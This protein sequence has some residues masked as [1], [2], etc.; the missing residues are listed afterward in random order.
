VILQYKILLSKL[1]YTDLLGLPAWD[2]ANSPLADCVQSLKRNEL[3]WATLQWSRETDLP[4]IACHPADLIGNTFTW[5][6]TEGNQVKLCVSKLPSSL[7][8][9]PVQ[10]PDVPAISLDLDILPHMVHSVLHKIDVS[11][12]LLV[13]VSCS[14]FVLY[15]GIF[16]SR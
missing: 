7:R 1:H 4:F 15:L 3:A 16:F 8:H 6:V 14:E 11:Q 9:E 2:N 12:D 10:G 13:M 5:I